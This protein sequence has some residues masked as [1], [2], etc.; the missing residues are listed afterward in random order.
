MSSCI[1]I[2]PQE[3]VKLS[4]AVLNHTIKITW[5][6]STIKDKLFGEIKGRIHALESPI[7]KTSF[8]IMIVPQFLLLLYQLLRWQKMMWLF[9]YNLACT[10]QSIDLE[11]WSYLDSFMNMHIFY[12]DS[13]YLKIEGPDNEFDR[14]MDYWVLWITWRGYQLED[15]QKIEARKPTSYQ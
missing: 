13:E 9:S 3:A 1:W 14:G 15:G 6:K 11:H 7:I 8:I 4:R 5:F 2:N 10:F 12:G